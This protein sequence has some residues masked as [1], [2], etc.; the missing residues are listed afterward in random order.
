M[1]LIV[2]C[3]RIIKVF[4]YISKYCSSNLAIWLFVGLLENY[5]GSFTE[6][7]L[8]IVNGWESSWNKDGPTLFSCLFALFRSWGSTFRL[9]VFSLPLLR[10]LRKCSAWH[11]LGRLSRNALY[12]SLNVFWSF[13][14]FWWKNCLEKVQNNY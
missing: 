13:F 8:I 6:M 12:G 7:E 11:F 4:K 2:A 14:F 3:H 1:T 5:Y 9:F 10:L